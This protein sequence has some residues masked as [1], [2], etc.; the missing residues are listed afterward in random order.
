MSCWLPGQQVK[1]EEEPTSLTSES[2]GSEEGSGVSDGD[3]AMLDDEDDAEMV[4]A[5]EVEMRS[6]PPRRLIPTGLFRRVAE[7][8]P[9]R[10]FDL[11]RSE[12]LEPGSDV[13]A[14]VGVGGGQF[15]EGGEER[16]LHPFAV[17]QIGSLAILASKEYASRGVEEVKAVFEHWAELV[18]FAFSTTTRCSTSDSR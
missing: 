15:R 9:E 1:D 10:R 17:M 4:M 3:E 6:S 8:E 16:V 14:A 2:L 11:E 7:W 12:G 5:G 13:G 18:S